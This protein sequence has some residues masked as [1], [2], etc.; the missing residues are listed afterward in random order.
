M[1]IDSI[2]DAKL[3]KNENNLPP[4]YLPPLFF[5]A[6]LLAANFLTFHFRMSS[7]KI[8]NLPTSYPYKAYQ[9]KLIGA[10]NSSPP[11]HQANMYMIYPIVRMDS[12]KPSLTTSIHQQFQYQS[13]N[14]ISKSSHEVNS[15]T[16]I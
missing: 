13:R 14:A 3:L 9:K 11:F 5:F 10:T 2:R 16:A 8:I 7:Y 1:F 15:Q 6:L 4:A 12:G